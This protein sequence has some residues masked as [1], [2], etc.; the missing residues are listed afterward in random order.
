M[1]ALFFIF[2][3]F[4]FVSLFYVVT[5]A[6][7]H[8]KKDHAEARSMTPVV[9]KQRDPGTKP[10]EMLISCVPH[11]QNN[12]QDNVKQDAMN[13][14]LGTF[15][16]DPGVRKYGLYELGSDYCLHNGSVQIYK[17]ASKPLS[18]DD[19]WWVS[20][21]LSLNKTFIHCYKQ[22]M[23]ERY[24]LPSPHSYPIL[25]SIIKSNTFAVQKSIKLLKT[26]LQD[27]SSYS[28]H[29]HSFDLNDCFNKFR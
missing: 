22:L 1:L 21:V 20:S 11:Y 2:F 29:V 27:V 7:R 28:K 4:F 12:F 3:V 24:V 19:G 5:I 6:S 23:S 14:F 9:Y 8:L 25:T 18:I 17:K 16:L 26:L 15:Q 13:L 10:T